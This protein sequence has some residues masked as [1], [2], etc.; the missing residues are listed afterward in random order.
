MSNLPGVTVQ[1][2]HGSPT[3]FNATVFLMSGRV[4]SLEVA[5]C[6]FWERGP[7]PWAERGCESRCRPGEAG[8]EGWGLHPYQRGGITCPQH[9][10]LTWALF[11]IFIFVT[12]RLGVVGKVR[13]QQLYGLR[14]RHILSEGWLQC[15]S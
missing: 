2:A 1:V 7:C 13:Y 10:V 4:A 6:G 3:S 15:G 11:E 9:N 8:G 5:N 14:L 12:G